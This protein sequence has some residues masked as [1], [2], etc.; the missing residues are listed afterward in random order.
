MN[1]AAGRLLGRIARALDQI[2]LFG[3]VRRLPERRRVDIVADLVH[4]TLTRRTFVEWEA[5]RI[6]VTP[7]HFYQ[8]IP[9]TAALPERLWTRT[10]DLGGVALCLDAQEGLLGRLSAYEREYDA[11]PDAPVADPLQFHFANQAFGPVDAEALY[12]LVRLLRPRQVVEVGAGWSTRLIAQALRAN[13]GED[14]GGAGRLLSIDV[15]PDPVL[16]PL[17]EILTRR[18]QDVDASVFAR[19]GANDILFV[20]SSHVVHIGSDCVYEVLDVLPSLASGVVVH[21]HDVFLPAEYPRSW[22]L[23]HHRFWNEQY[24]L[25]AFL[26]FNSEFEVLLA[27]GALHSLRPHLLRRAF[28]RYV[29]GVQPASL[30]LRRR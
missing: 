20:D 1:S 9:D 30:W 23:D 6:H 17:G 13:A 14:G 2:G 29:E 8:P 18:I 4:T 15:S 11:L 10:S 27:T 7:V 24:L 3:L 28:R 5:R 21:F 19:L 22:I 25:Q 26:A 16:E 12:A